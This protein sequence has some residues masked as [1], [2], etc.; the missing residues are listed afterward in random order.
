MKS[1]FFL[2][3]TQPTNGSFR[4]FWTTYRFHL[5]RSSSSWDAWPLKMGPETS[6]RNY[7]CKLRN[8]ARGHRSCRHD[9]TLYR[10]YRNYCKNTTF[11]SNKK[12]NTHTKVKHRRLHDCV[13]QLP[14]VYLSIFVY[15]TLVVHSCWGKHGFE[16]ET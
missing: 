2:D 10:A 14:C 15:T 4:R 5:R 12:R 13:P 8:I 11:L 7:H 3:F 1:A 9:L 6:G 16:C